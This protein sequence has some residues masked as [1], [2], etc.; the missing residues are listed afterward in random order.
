MRLSQPQDRAPPL[1]API[2]TR[3]KMAV[4]ASVASPVLVRSCSRR[5]SIGA[6]AACCCARTAGTACTTCRHNLMTGLGCWLPHARPRHTPIGHSSRDLPA[7]TYH[8]VLWQ[9]A[10]LEQ[11]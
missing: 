1:W 5:E 11:I 10:A 4:S 9:P 7:C 6:P 2:L 8:A 3:T